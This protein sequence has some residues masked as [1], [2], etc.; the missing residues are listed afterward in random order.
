MVGELCSQSE[1]LEEAISLDHQGERL[2][3]LSALMADS[4][5]TTTIRKVLAVKVA[6][7][8]TSSAR[9]AKELSQDGVSLAFHEV[10]A[11]GSF[12]GCCV[13]IHSTHLPGM[14]I[15]V[16]ANKDGDS[17]NVILYHHDEHF[18]LLCPTSAAPLNCIQ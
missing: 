3:R 12:L 15:S 4:D 14:P 5:W 1:S 2:A 17:P 9:E 10:G 8:P 11:F 7:L 6:V 18:D 16:G 13:T